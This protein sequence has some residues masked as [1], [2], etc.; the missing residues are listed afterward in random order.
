[1]SEWWKYHSALPFPKSSWEVLN[2]ESDHVHIHSHKPSLRNDIQNVGPFWL[3]PLMLCLVSLMPYWRYVQFTLQCTIL[4][5]P[6][7]DFYLFTVPLAY[8]A[9]NYLIILHWAQLKHNRL[10]LLL[11]KS[12]ISA[13]AQQ[14]TKHR[15]DRLLQLAFYYVLGINEILLFFGW[16]SGLFWLLC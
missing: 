11:Q 16:K 14:H 1:M 2:F 4:L 6:A 8:Q 13:S 5:I 3:V 12:T 15:R 10:T 7:L 9:F